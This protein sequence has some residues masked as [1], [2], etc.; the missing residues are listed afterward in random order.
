MWESIL[1]SF[2]PFDS[3]RFHYTLHIHLMQ[4][5]VLSHSTMKSFCNLFLSLFHFKLIC[6]KEQHQIFPILIIKIQIICLFS[7]IEKTVPKNFITYSHV[8]LQY[9]ASQR[10]K[11][12]M[13]YT[14][15]L[16][17]FMGFFMELYMAI[18]KYSVYF[19]KG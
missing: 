9:I 14:N 2:F 4:V 3:L 13:L 11:I 17:R 15:N 8:F 18:T 16:K 10:N 5:S 7:P 1:F 12:C 6:L 19:D